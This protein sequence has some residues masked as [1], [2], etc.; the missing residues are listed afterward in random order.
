[1]E[2]RSN[3]QLDD[4]SQVAV[5]GGGPAG[6]FFS[7]FLLDMAERVGMDV[8]VDIYEPRDFTSPG[9]TGCNHCGGI[10]HESVVQ[11]LATD[12][13]N[14]PPTVV[15]RGIDSHVLHMGVGSVRIETPLQEKRIGAM[16]RGAGPRG[17]KEKKWDSLDGY[18]LSLAVGKGANVIRDRVKDVSWNDGRP[19]IITRDD[20]LKI[21]DLVVAA[22]GV[23]TAAL[24]LFEKLGMGYKPPRTV[25]AFVR[26]YYV[27]EET[28][29]SYL[30]SS[31]HVILV[32]IPGLEFAALI[33]KGDYVTL[34]M[35]GDEK[36]K[37]FAESLLERPEVKERFPPDFDLSHPSCH[38]SP[39][40][41]VQGAVQPYGD[42]IIFIGDCG[43]TRFYKDG[44]GSAYRAAKA[45]AVTAVFEGI[46]AS[47]FKRRYWPVCRTLKV[48]NAIARVVFAIVRQIQR[49]RFARRA[50]LRMV[51]RE[52]QKGDHQQRLSMVMWDMY[53]GS[54]PYWEIFLRTLHPG[55]WVRFLG[56]LIVSLPE[57]R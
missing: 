15:Q 22:V 39:R 18:L 32:D 41:S 47:D 30:G 20:S 50:V 9:P 5:I 17:I 55:F 51:T 27:G 38:C 6:S 49:R 29:E 7:Y 12:G 42:R 57:K 11:I 14:L 36:N 25:K 24:R 2:K 26:E 19:Q 23:N 45:A 48:D 34:C 56:D 35:I 54:S 10:V 28:V 52:Q 21:Y 33:P 43:V 40:I 37:G 44:I 46:S 13:I 3:L 8:Q 1:V 4:G 16:Y 53:T 31:V